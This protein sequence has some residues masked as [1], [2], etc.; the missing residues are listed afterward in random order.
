MAKNAISPTRKENFPK[1][2]QEVVRQADLATHSSARGCMTIHPWGY[3]I[4]EHM[5]KTLDAM[6]K[7]KGVENGSQ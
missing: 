3:A 4:W 6:F 7:Q 5:Q 2:Y 1:W